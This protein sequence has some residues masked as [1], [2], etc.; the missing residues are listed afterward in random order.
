[1]LLHM[2]TAGRFACC[3]KKIGYITNL[4]GWESFVKE[5]M[6]DI[7]LLQLYIFKKRYLLLR[8]GSWDSRLHPKKKPAEMWRASLKDNLKIPW[9]WI[10]SLIKHFS[11]KVGKIVA[12]TQPVLG[13][14]SDEE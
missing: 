9:L 7:E 1:M 14:E 11:I 5:F 3:S 6:L 10:T 13:A 8:F 4:F 12:I 2:L